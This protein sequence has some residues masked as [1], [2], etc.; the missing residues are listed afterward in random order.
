MIGS[1]VGSPN[2][3]GTAYQNRIHGLPLKLLNEECLFLLTECTED[4]KLVEQRLGDPEQI[5]RCAE[6]FHDFERRFQC[7]YIPIYNRH[8]IEQIKQRLDLIVQGKAFKNKV[9]VEEIDRDQILA[10]EIKRIKQIDKDNQ[11]KQ[12]LIQS[13]WSLCFK[14]VDFKFSDTICRFD[15][16][17]Q[18]KGEQQQ[19]QRQT[20][21]DHI[22]TLGNEHSLLRYL[23]YKDLNK[24]G[25]YLTKGN[26][27]GSD[28][29]AYPTDPLFCHAQYLVVCL[30]E[31][32]QLTKTLL[33]TY[34]RLGSQVNKN[35]LLV[36]FEDTTT[37]RSN[38][39]GRLEYM[40]IKWQSNN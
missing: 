31:N 21:T 23:V 13:P 29:L 37:N 25:L 28:F 32:Q 4:V 1:F 3:T 5:E 26:K 19:Q 17:S 39:E 14:V 18:S 24:K 34:T 10:D 35:V 15:E 40:V 20:S 9:P 16:M 8:S 2:W 7:D 22:P 33:H 27:F 38:E 6:E 30:S 11:P 12:L 36:R